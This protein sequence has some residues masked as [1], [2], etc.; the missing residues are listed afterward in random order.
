VGLSTTASGESRAFLW[1]NGTML[2][3]G[4]LGGPSIGSTANAI[5]N[6]G[7]VVGGSGTAS[8]DFHA[9]LWQDGTMTDLT[10]LIKT[11]SSA[12]SINN[13]GQIVGIGEG[14]SFLWQHGKITDL[15]PGLVYDIND[16]SQVVGEAE[17]DPGTADRAFLWQSGTI[18]DLGTLG[19]ASSIAQSIN[20]RGQVVGVSQT[21]EEAGE[22]GVAHAF[23][24]QD[25]IMIDLGTLGG[26]FGNA[27][28]INDRGQITGFTQNA[29]HEFHAVLWSK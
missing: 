9:F 11:F 2:D 22:E 13:R 20:N 16:R 8:G 4:T 6:R 1:Q 26:P 5:N 28:A 19:G 29:S 3:L 21:A 14:Y 7:Q 12:Q 27:E 25:D 23:L 24:W 17:I 10:P 15:L 18:T